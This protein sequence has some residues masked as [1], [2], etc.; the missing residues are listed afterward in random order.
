MHTIFLLTYGVKKQFCVEF[1]KK[2]II[3]SYHRLC[4]ATIA[5]FAVG[6]IHQ[7]F[8]VKSTTKKKVVL[9]LLSF[10]EI[11]LLLCQGVWFSMV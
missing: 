4:S 5:F 8:N 7:D 1:F 2:K 10:S 9:E 6:L 3:A 11:T